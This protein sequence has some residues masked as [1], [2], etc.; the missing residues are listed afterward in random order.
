MSLPGL[1]WDAVYLWSA[2]TSRDAI[3]CPSLRIIGSSVT[4]VTAPMHTL[5]LARYTLNRR[6]NNKKKQPK[7]KSYTSVSF[8]AVVLTSL[9]FVAV[10]KSLESAS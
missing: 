4:Q 9:E 6:G 3:V 10:I 8:P 2:E 7:P 1:A 5:L